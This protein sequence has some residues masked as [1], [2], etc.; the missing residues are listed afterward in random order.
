MRP[1]FAPEAI[2]SDEELEAEHAELV[3]DSTEIVDIVEHYR[4]GHYSQAEMAE[5]IAHEVSQLEDWARE[6]LEE[7]KQEARDA[8]WEVA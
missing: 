8:G 6:R 5:L 4:A 2:Y 3:A 7:R 1:E